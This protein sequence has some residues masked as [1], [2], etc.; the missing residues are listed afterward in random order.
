MDLTQLLIF[1]TLKL[2]EQ[3]HFIE[4]IFKSILVISL[5]AR[6]CMCPIFFH[7][8]A[9]HLKTEKPLCI[10]II[11]QSGYTRVLGDHSMSL[12]WSSPSGSIGNFYM[13]L[14]L[15]SIK[16]LRRQRILI[17]FKAKILVKYG[18]VTTHFLLFFVMLLCVDLYACDREYKDCIW[19]YGLPVC[20][21]TN[22]HLY[23][24]M[25]T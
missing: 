16:I 6:V 22:K 15:W 1:V 8:R 23:D 7:N 25:L 20:L 24:V 12:H 5:H 19:E 14:K 11:S 13:V 2:K 21:S 9:P 4:I 17:I 10:R 3:N 18:M